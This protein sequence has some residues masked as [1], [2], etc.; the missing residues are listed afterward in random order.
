MHCQDRAF[1]I[2][3]RINNAATN[4]L[5]SETHIS[6]LICDIS[7]S[8]R[9]FIAGNICYYFTTGNFLEMVDRI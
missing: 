3:W 9:I 4:N 1:E 7:S 5:N 2:A 8:T 6:D